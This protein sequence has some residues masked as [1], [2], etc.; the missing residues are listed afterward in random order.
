MIIIIV[1]LV[2]ALVGLVLY[3]F[4]FSKKGNDTK[5]QTQNG[6][7]IPQTPTEEKTSIEVGDYIDYKPDNA[8]NYLLTETTTGSKDND[9]AGLKQENLKWRILSINSDGTVDIISEEPISTEV[10]FKGAIGFNNCV[11]LLNDICKK[12]Y[13]N[14]ELGTE[15][16]SLSIEDIENNMND[17]GIEG[18][19]SYSLNEV[20]YGD[21][22]I[23]TD[24][25]AYL[26]EIYT[27]VDMEASNRSISYYKKPTT[28]KY[29]QQTSIEMTQTFYKLDNL[30]SDYFENEDFYNLVFN[31]T[32]GSWIASRCIDCS[33]K[34]VALFGIYKIEDNSISGSGISTSAG[35]SGANKNY[36]RP[37]VTLGEN[38]EISELERGTSDEPRT[39]TK[40]ETIDNSDDNNI[41]NDIDDNNT[42]N[43]S[44]ID[45]NINENNN[46]ELN[47]N[48]MQNNMEREAFNSQFTPYEGEGISGAQVRSLISIITKS[49]N[50]NVANQ[51]KIEKP[52]EITNSK[53]YAVGF[54][55]DDNDYIKQAIISEL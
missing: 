24:S 33:S 16:R 26:P 15:A 18:R 1:L 36:I 5:I 12:Q 7:Q 39:L 19:N 45:T 42:N 14:K 21:K 10:Y 49:N 34:T 41:D 27:K 32:S 8:S 13:S 35:K 20:A 29:I 2:V 9:T 31:T 37:I 44:N 53:E 28:N 55:Y 4:V 52:E 30:T 51:V 22:V 11:Y 25:S 48:N 6:Q 46:N 54:A 38:I 23:Y 50:V 43:N 47:T 17:E 40:S 3:K